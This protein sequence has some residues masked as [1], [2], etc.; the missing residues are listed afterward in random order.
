MIIGIFSIRPHRY[1][2]NKRLLEAAKALG[3]R[4][5]LVDPRKMFLGIHDGGL[6]I[7]HLGRSFHVDV[8]L[9]RMGSTIKEY[10]LTVLRH[11]E[12]LGIRL[13]NNYNA[14]MLARNKF[15]T[16]Q[17]L[18]MNGIPV[19][20]SRYVSNWSNFNGAV[21][22]FGGYPLVMKTASGRQGEGVFLVESMDKARSL[23]EAIIRKGEGLL[24]QRYIPPER[25]RDIRV[26]VAGE[27]V[28]GAM[29]LIPRRGDFRANVHLHARMEMIQNDK[30]IQELALKSTRAL[31][32][33]ISGVD[34]IEEST[35]ML[36]VMEVNYSPGFR[37]L[38][39]CTGIDV[40][41]EII[42]FVVRSTGRERCI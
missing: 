39:K 17:A 28:V 30:K 7:D 16:L 21:S 4:A 2:P 42:Q 40:A 27:G 20:E 34:M 41:S 36:R 5:I 29:S 18:S 37:G 26:L 6:R 3:Q 10:P 1:H 22:E 35:G 13:I 12:L 38:E 25:R 24:L 23:F 33:D 8:V 15:L 19:L 9:P 31:G 11:F 32:L 14:I